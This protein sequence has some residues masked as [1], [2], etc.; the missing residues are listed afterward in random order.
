MVI[1][2]PLVGCGVGRVLEYWCLS[3]TFVTSEEYTVE[4]ALDQLDIS[5]EKGQEVMEKVDNL[6][7]DRIYYTKELLVKK[8]AGV[9]I[10]WA[11]NNVLDRLL[12]IFDAGFRS[13]IPICQQE[14]CKSKLHEGPIVYGE[15]IFSLANIIDQMIIT[16]SNDNKETFPFIDSFPQN[17][18]INFGAFFC[19]KEYGNSL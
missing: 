14:L 15:G 10:S 2:A 11:F 13:V 6:G 9:K 17:H 12:A 19:N 1:K 16:F 8:R 3:D 18:G 5:T 7:C 4:Q